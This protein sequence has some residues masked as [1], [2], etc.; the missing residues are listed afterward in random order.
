MKNK[1]YIIQYYM[2]NDEKINRIYMTSINS[3]SFNSLFNNLF[4]FN[5]EIEEIK[6]LFN[7][8]IKRIKIINKILNYLIENKMNKTL[9]FFISLDETTIDRTERI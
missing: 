9:L 4:C 5:I 8:I 1:V 7:E 6:L 3:S 2:F